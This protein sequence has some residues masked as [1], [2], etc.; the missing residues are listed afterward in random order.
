MARRK[1]NADIEVS[2]RILAGFSGTHYLDGV[3]DVRQALLILDQ[4]VHN[5]TSRY[6]EELTPQIDGE[7]DTFQTTHPFTSVRAV[8]NGLEQSEGVDADY[9]VVDSTH[10]QFY[11][12]LKIT[13]TLTVEL[14]LA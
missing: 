2:G 1:V 4:I 3:T 11:R 10:I 7:K 9:V 8:L 12:P 5:L 13:E 14:V 6:R